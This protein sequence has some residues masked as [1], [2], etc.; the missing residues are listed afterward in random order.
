MYA[1]ACMC[2]EVYIYHL[3]GMI[4]TCMSVY[5]VHTQ[6]LSPLEGN[7]EQSL[8]LLQTVTAVCNNNNSCGPKLSIYLM[9]RQQLCGNTWINRNS[10]SKRLVLGSRCSKQFDYQQDCCAIANFPAIF[11]SS[12]FAT[13]V[14]Y[15]C[16]NLDRI[17][18]T[19]IIRPYN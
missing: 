12:V 4:S 11:S 6:N 10:L 15:Q 18:R 16:H 1:L 13:L 14:C 9:Q 19:T 3:T 7:S 8:L 5:N 17:A 2:A